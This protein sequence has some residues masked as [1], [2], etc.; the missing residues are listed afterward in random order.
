MTEAIA[1]HSVAESAL[2][3]IAYEGSDFASLLEREFKPRSDE[4][5]SAVQSAVQ[6]L[7]EQALSQTKLISDDVVMSIEAMIAELDRKLS[8]Q[9]NVI[10]HHPEFQQLESAW[11]GLDYLVSNTETDESMKIRVMNISKAELGK[12]LKRFKGSA[13]DQS[14]FFK[15][16]Y[17]QEFGQFGGNPYGCLVGDFY[18][19]Q[20]P[21]DVELLAN[22]AKISASAH[23]PFLAAAD[24]K[25][26]QMES[27]EGPG[28]SA[29]P[30][31]DLHDTGI[32]GVAHLA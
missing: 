25:L 2:G 32:F 11:R 4:A 9:I 1:E 28:Q 19:N 14:P 6:T 31:Q 5:K 13:W 26:L 27:W 29:R 21:P 16:I 8:E 10:L 30:R 17:E 15:Q 20:S 23:A 22:L 18:F 12:T 7:A 24:P 3:G